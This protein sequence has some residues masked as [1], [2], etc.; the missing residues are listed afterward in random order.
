MTSRQNFEALKEWI[1]KDDI[2]VEVDITYY[3]SIAT[4]ES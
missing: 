1:Q 3:D 2:D 4:P